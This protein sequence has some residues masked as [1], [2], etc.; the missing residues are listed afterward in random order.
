[1]KTVTGEFDTRREADLA[2]ERLVQEY[3]VERTDIF[4]APEGKDN[5]AGQAVDGADLTTGPA[6]SEE[7]DDSALRGVLAI[8]ID[9]AEED[10][11]V[12]KNALTAAGA[13]HTNI[14]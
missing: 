5:S 1:M 13:I 2:I 3:G 7:R 8:S 12:V 4:V 10:A 11:E 9:I 14:K 6:G